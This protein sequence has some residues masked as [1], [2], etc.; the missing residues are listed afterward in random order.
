MRKLTVGVCYTKSDPVGIGAAD[1][2]IEGIT[3]SGD[4]VFK[5]R[6][7]ES[8][9]SIVYDV[10]VQVCDYT[11]YLGHDFRY[12]IKKHCNKYNI[13]RIII[14][15][16]FVKNN[17]MSMSL[18][19][20][21]EIGIGGIKNAAEYYNK[22]SGSDRWDKLEITL[23]P[24]RKQG[25]H[26]LILGQ[27]EKGVSVQDIDVVKWM[28]DT[29]YFLTNKMKIKYPI[30]LRPHPNQIVFPDGNYIKTENTTIEEDL[31]NA[32]CTV[33]KTTNGAIDSI[34]RGIPVITDDKMN[35]VYDI[36]GHNLV[37]VLNP[38]MFDR[39]QWCYN[40]AYAQ[41]HITEMKKGLPWQHLR[42]KD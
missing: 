12:Y 28:T 13:P 21:M 9:S 37:E 6:S 40:L 2:F 5:I 34:L 1:A 19:R 26:I 15:T 10:M 29:I 42:P 41:W 22:D 11:H 36:A 32:W 14:D 18:D 20:Y 16:G 31:G 33:A 25:S 7:V 8:L 27:H 4:Q 30:V 39:K 35:M 38:L 3:N 17:R 24:W 23:K